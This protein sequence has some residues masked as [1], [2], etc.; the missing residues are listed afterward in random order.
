MEL[1]KINERFKALSSELSKHDT[2]IKNNLNK[3]A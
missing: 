2:Q 3:I 1:I